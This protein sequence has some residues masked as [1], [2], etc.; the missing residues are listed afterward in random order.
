[1]AG[2]FTPSLSLDAGE[3]G[4]GAGG[5]KW[6]SRYVTSQSSLLSD[7]LFLNAMRRDEKERGF[8][9][10]ACVMFG[11]LSFCLLCFWF[12]TSCF[13]LFLLSL[14][15]CNTPLTFVSSIIDQPTGHPSVSQ[16][17]SPPLPQPP[18]PP[19]PPLSL[20]ATIIEH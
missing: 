10:A 3:S 20:N 2:G 18:A 14:G 17:L 13:C 11:F 19:P 6:C 4:R 7:L 15:K 16:T 8:S 5:V 1:M 12:N 9:T